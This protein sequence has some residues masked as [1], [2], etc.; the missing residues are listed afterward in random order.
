MHFWI[1]M[2]LFHSQVHTPFL[3]P[4]VA[5]FSLPC[6]ICL[7]WFSPQL[8][9]LSGRTKIPFVCV[10]DSLHS[11]PLSFL[12]SFSPSP[13]TSFFQKFFFV[14]EKAIFQPGMCFWHA[15]LPPCFFAL[16]FPVCRKEKPTKRRTKRRWN[17]N[18][19][20]WKITFPSL[21]LAPLKWVEGN[22]TTLIRVSPL[23]K[24]KKY[25]LNEQLSS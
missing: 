11:F 6:F 18:G 8:A 19:Q 12:C 3:P 10:S 1:K 4:H 25:P 16:I 21:L 23:K 20:L 2:V 22:F 9:I 24:K 17:T 5:F 15:Y 14:F 7:N 13:A